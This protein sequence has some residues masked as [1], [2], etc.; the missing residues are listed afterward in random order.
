MKGTALVATLMLVIAL[1]G[2]N[3]PQS[4]DAASGRTLVARGTTAAAQT[5]LPRMVELGADY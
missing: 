2:C 3:Q 1:A 4:G 5:G